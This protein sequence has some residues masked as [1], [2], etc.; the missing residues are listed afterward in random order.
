MSPGQTLLEIHIARTELGIALE[1][2]TKREIASPLRGSHDDEMQVGA[3]VRL[4]TLGQD[5]PTSLTLIPTR[6]KAGIDQANPSTL[7]RRVATR[8]RGHVDDRLGDQA[9]HGRAPNVLNRHRKALIGRQPDTAPSETDRSGPPL[10]AGH[11]ARET[12]RSRPAPPT[13][14]ARLR[15]WPPAVGSPRPSSFDKFAGGRPDLGDHSRRSAPARVEQPPP[16]H[17]RHVGWESRHGKEANIVGFVAGDRPAGSCWRSELKHEGR[18]LR[19][20]VETRQPVRG[21]VDAGLFSSLADSRLPWRLPRLDRSARCFPHIDVSTMYQQHLTT[22][23][24]RCDE[25][26]ETHRPLRLGLCV[27]PRASGRR[28]CYTESGPRCDAAGGRGDSGENRGLA[29]LQWKRRPCEPSVSSRR[30]SVR[31]APSRERPR[32]LQRNL[33]CPPL[34]RAQRPCSPRGQ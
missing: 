10:R 4:G 20:P 6:L 32:C 8:A 13:E 24:E 18:L 23:V 22:F 3:S 9:R 14:H 1:Q 28:R 30:R 17:R 26:T 21:D 29:V 34:A 11:L 12:S 15:S 31:K 5:Q 25:R 27:L 16:Y 7:H 33:H 2:V 19:P